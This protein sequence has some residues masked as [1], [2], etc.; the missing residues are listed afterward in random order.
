VHLFK[1]GPQEEEMAGKIPIPEEAEQPQKIREGTGPGTRESGDPPN[2]LLNQKSS[3]S[4]FNLVTLEPDNESA[5][6]QSAAPMKTDAQKTD[7]QEATSNEAQLCNEAGSEHV[8][9]ATT[10]WFP[11]SDERCKGINDLPQGVPV[12]AF[13]FMDGGDL[14]G[15]IDKRHETFSW[16]IGDEE[17]EYERC[18]TSS[19][20]ENRDI[21]RQVME[22]LE[23]LHSKRIVHRDIKPE[24]I[25]LT[26]DRQNVKV[27]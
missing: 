25:L 11:C 18:Y 5:G 19:E 4:G 2:S 14:A 17:P 22:G 20:K 3:S 16:K 15:I 24:N 21:I 13:E 27:L 12:I 23:T 1:V 6:F 7:E 9:G 8:L 10:C 26:E